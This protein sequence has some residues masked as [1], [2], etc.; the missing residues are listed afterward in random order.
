MKRISAALLASFMLFSCSITLYKGK[1]EVHESKQNPGSKNFAAVSPV[2]AEYDTSAIE[3]EPIFKSGLNVINLG[4][5]VNTSEADYAPA[6]TADGKT[7]YFISN[8]DGSIKAAKDSKFF[9]SFEESEK[10]HDFWVLKKTGKLDKVFSEPY[11]IKNTNKIAELNTEFNEGSCSISGD[12]KTM[13]FAGCNRPGGFG[14]CDILCVSIDG[15]S[16]GNIIT[17]WPNISSADW[18]SQPSVTNNQDRV[19][20]SSNRPGPNGLKNNDIWYSDWDDERKEFKPARNLSEINSPGQEWSPFISPDGL[21]L[22]FSSDGLEPNF[23]G[24][25]LYVTRFNPET[26]KWTKP[27]NLGKPIN[28]DKNDTFL[29]M[30]PSGDVIY[31][32]SDRTDIPGYQGGYDIFMALPAN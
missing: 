28:S 6:V 16:I 14:S 24:F 19:Y 30:P 1:T 13:F 29:T 15:D 4:E 32:S 27:K 7:I 3:L 26:K 9:K 2:K 10:S 8:R 12:G 11:H 20:F 18:D 25:D 23:G 17:L 5:K 22:Y 21:T 31:F